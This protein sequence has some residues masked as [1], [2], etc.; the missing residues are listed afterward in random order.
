MLE[1]QGKHLEATAILAEARGGSRIQ[2][3]YF[4]KREIR[5][6]VDLHEKNEAA[7]FDQMVTCRAGRLGGKRNVNWQE[8]KRGIGNVL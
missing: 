5:Y 6:G 1:D 2:R 4:F 7:I 8:E 3:G